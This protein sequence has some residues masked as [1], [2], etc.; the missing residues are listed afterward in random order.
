MITDSVLMFFI[1]IYMSVLSLIPDPG[2][3]AFFTDTGTGSFTGA[4][5]WVTSSMGP[6]AGWVNLPALYL[7]I[8]WG[9]FAMAAQHTWHVTRAFFKAV[10]G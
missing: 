8:V 4:M 7:A 3:P 9:A 2:Y 6:M 5:T 1:N 10:R